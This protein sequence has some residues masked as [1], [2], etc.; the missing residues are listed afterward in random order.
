MATNTKRVGNIG[1][2]KNKIIFGVREPNLTDIFLKTSWLNTSL[3][4]EVVIFVQ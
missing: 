4:I 2:I 3:Q 1:A